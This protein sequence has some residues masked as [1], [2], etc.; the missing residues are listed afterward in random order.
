MP[1]NRTGSG[2]FRGVI[3]RSSGGQAQRLRRPL[4]GYQAGGRVGLYET[5]GVLLRGRRVG[6]TV[7]AI[8]LNQFSQIVARKARK[9]GIP[10]RQIGV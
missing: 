10:A 9:T 1:V 4:I 8:P 7:G 5:R 6:I 2:E 3:H